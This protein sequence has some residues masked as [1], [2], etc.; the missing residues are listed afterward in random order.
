MFN[1]GIRP[2][3]NAGVSV[4]RVGGSAQTKIIKKLSGGIRTALAQ[5]R[6]LAAFSQFAS[7]L[8]EA[9]KAQLNHGERV[10]E[11]MKQQQY[12]PMTVSRMALVLYCANEGCLEDV[13]VKDGLKFERD[14]L[15][16][17]EH[18]AKDMVDNINATGDWN[19]ELEARFKEL[20]EKFKSQ[21]V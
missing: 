6:D 16:C 14:L 18:E 12:S 19:A 20:V 4:S 17:A 15:A 10:T 1:A 9:T 7:D 21:N 8:D 3:M 5:Y 11:L 13:E 2:S